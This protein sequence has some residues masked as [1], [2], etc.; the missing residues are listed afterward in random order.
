MKR[1]ILFRAK[2]IHKG[3]WIYGSLV[4]KKGIDG[5]SVYYIQRHGGLFRIDFVD[6][7]SVCQC[8]GLK[9]VDGH[10]IFEGDIVVLFNLGK[11]HHLVV[12]WSANTCQFQ[13]SSAIDN[14]WFTDLRDL[15]D[16]EIIGNIH[17]NPELL[18]D[19]TS[20]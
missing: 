4:V 7:S 9:S 17:D 18:K 3:Y 20:S 11:K 14:V 2:H 8:V 10:R 5:I 6:V 16:I 1:E 13:L 19:E 12:E 15:L